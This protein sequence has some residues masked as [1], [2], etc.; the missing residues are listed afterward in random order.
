[1]WAPARQTWRTLASDPSA[2]A[3][4]HAVAFLHEEMPAELHLEIVRR[5]LG[6]RSSKVR[7]KA[8]EMAG[9]LELRELLPE[10]TA[11]RARET[12]AELSKQLDLELALMRDG[13][14]LE[15][16]EGKTHEYWIRI[17]RP[18][19]SISLPFFG[20]PTP[21][22]IVARIVESDRERGTTTP[23][24]LLASRTGGA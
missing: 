4:R 23:S 14:V 6:D 15:P 11:L 17:R 16:L 2:T 8:I 5:A 13:Y 9:S 10:L 19:A 1:M 3:R 24:W 12:D 7:V 20:A 18:N 21:E 22:A